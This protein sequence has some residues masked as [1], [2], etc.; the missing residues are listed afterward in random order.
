METEIWKEVPDYE[1]YDVSTLGGIRRWNIAR[2]RNKEI[3]ATTCSN[4]PYKMFTVSKHAKY[5]K[6]YLHRII[7]TLFVANKKPL[8]NTH[9]CF[10]DGNIANT[11]ASN[12][13]WSNQKERMTR[14]KKEGGYK[15][16]KV[17]HAKLSKIDVLTIRWMDHHK[18]MSHKE[19]AEY[20]GVH[21][22]T[23]YAC[24]KRITWKHI[25]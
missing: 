18:A 16:S 4:A 2:T 13:Y 17:P 24:V 5:T 20:F 11:I 19:M 15:G 23:I 6:L 12:L 3:F 10:K 22:W 8:E 7:A 14:R 25:K 21:R 9:V 1:S